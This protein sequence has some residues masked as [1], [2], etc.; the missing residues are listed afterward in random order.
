MQRK[1]FCVMP[2]Q[3]KFNFKCATNLIGKITQLE[4]NPHSIYM[5]VTSKIQLQKM[6]LNCFARNKILVLLT[7]K[8]SI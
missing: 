1:I 6:D 3:S 7:Y 5:C 8:I 2:Q 4:K